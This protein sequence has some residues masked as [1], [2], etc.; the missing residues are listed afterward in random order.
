CTDDA[1]QPTGRSAYDHVVDLL[2]I[3]QGQEIKRKM[4]CPEF[5]ATGTVAPPLSRCGLRR[6]P[7]LNR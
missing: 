5:A 4:L 3:N 6:L 2:M 1:F 7:K